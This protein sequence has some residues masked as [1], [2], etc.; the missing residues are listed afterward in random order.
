VCRLVTLLATTDARRCML[1]SILLACVRDVAT[2]KEAAAE[3]IATLQS[4]LQDDRLKCFAVCVSWGIAE[5]GVADI[6]HFRWPRCC[7]LSHA[8]RAT[9]VV[10]GSRGAAAAVQRCDR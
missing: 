3:Y 8:T 5:G 10:G 7:D 2:A 4:M 9:P 6:D 1:T